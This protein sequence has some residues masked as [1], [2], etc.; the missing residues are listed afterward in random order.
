MIFLH[1]RTVLPALSL[2]LSIPQSLA[3]TTSDCDPLTEDGCSSDPA[4]GESITIDFTSGSS[5]QFTAS[6]SPSYGSSG[7]EFTISEKGDSP[8]IT[9]SWY[10]MFG[11]VEYVVK[12]APGTGIVSSAVL[13]SD[14]LDEIDWEWLGGDDDKAQSNYFG[15]GIT[16]TYNRGA[17]HAVAN[18][19]DEF[20]SYTVDWTADRIVWGIDGETVRTL[21]EEDADSGQYPQTPMQVKVGSWAGGDSSNSEG[22]IEWAGGLVDYSDGPFTMYLKSISVT[23]YSTGT[24]YSY[25]GTSGTWESIKSD[26]GTVNGSSSDTST[27]A[28]TVASSAA[29]T[30]TSSVSNN[31]P[32]AFGANDASE[33]VTR[34]GWP[35]D[36]SATVSIATSVAKSTAG[37][38]SGWP[39][40]GSALLSSLSSAASSSASSL[41]SGL[42][43]STSYDS[44]GFPTVV[45]INPA[46]TTQPKSDIIKWTDFASF[47]NVTFVKRTDFAFYVNSTLVDLKSVVKRTDFT[48]FD[49]FTFINNLIDQIQILNIIVYRE[50]LFDSGY[51]NSRVFF[52]RGD[53]RIE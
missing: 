44:Q 14:C 31:A 41:A 34:T 16:T 47:V 45:T 38:P 33:T 25:S 39:S 18:N 48:F 23:D 4:L 3:Q 9:S 22:T 49:N 10:I 43:L 19:H 11:H 42:E 46:T 21:T 29:S 40:S 30:V 53:A 7:A 37:L 36:A 35:W 32:L 17:Y 15:K 2:L 26:G 50:R 28:T 51:F 24:S 6:G 1:A 20:H 13:L 5:S 27:S 52:D 8:T 12:A